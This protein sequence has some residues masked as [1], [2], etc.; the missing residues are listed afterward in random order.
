MPRRILL[1]L[2]QAPQDPSSGAARSLRTICRLLA[3]RR[4]PDGT[5]EFSVRAVG[6]TATDRGTWPDGAPVAALAAMGF[7]VTRQ[8]VPGQ[9]GAALLAFADHGVFTR[10]VDTDGTPGEL[11]ASGQRALDALLADELRTAPPDVCLTFGGNSAD[12][13]RRKRVRA[14]GAAV[15]FG[16][17]Q[18]GYLHAPRDFFTPAHAI[19]AV[20][21]PSEFLLRRYRET[22][23]IPAG[24]GLPSALDPAEVVAPEPREPVFVTFINPSQEKGVFF[25]VR[26][27]EQLSLRRPDIPLLVQE[28]RGTRDTLLAAARAGGIDLARFE[29]ILI[30]PPV[31]APREI[32]TNAR[33]LLA[34]SVWEEPAG[35][36]VSEALLNGVPPLVADRGGLPD[37]AN[38]GGLVLPLPSDFT[39]AATRPVEAAAVR[40]WVD[41]IEH[42]CSDESAYAAAC[43]RAR[44][45]SRRYLVGNVAPLYSDFFRSV[46]RAAVEPVREPAAI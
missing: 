7:T 32:F 45:A 46:V 12:H 5:P 34:P 19:D 40:P 15:V 9:R 4:L 30:S 29:N 20:L 39:L 3:D 35:R 44:A 11:R 28:S 24:A 25:F 38:G 18:W 31:A 17:R 1:L 16:L 6:T 33:L 13:A 8:S 26:L 36:V 43:T 14:T 42:L 10:L 22:Y 2:P 37:E 23:Q 41:A 27:A 21:T